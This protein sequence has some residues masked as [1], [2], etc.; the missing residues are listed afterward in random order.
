MKYGGEVMKEEIEEMIRAVPNDIQVEHPENERI[1]AP[2]IYPL[3][4]HESS[5]RILLDHD[6]SMHQPNV[7][8]DNPL[9]MIPLNNEP[10]IINQPIP[11]SINVQPI[12]N[13]A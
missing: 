2:S 6:N 10:E 4:I 13:N 11:E 1:I 7:Q 8:P 3:V 5:E 12:E 9:P